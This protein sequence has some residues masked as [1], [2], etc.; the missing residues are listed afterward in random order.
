M[1]SKLIYFKFIDK[2]THVYHKNGGTVICIF[3][4]SLKRLESL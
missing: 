4:V 1:K 2:S 3:S